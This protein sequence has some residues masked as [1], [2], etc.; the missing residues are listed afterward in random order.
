MR[1]YYLLILSLFLPCLL[2]AQE[3]G[4]MGRHFLF[5]AQGSS[6][7]VLR[8]AYNNDL[9]PNNSPLTFIPGLRMEYILSRSNTMLL[10]FVPIRTASVSEFSGAVTRERCLGVGFHYKTYAFANRGNLAPMGMFFE[11]GLN[12]YYLKSTIKDVNEPLEERTGVAIRPV[13]AF[14]NSF[15]TGRLFYEICF[16]YQFLTEVNDEY[17]GP[18][19]TNF[20]LRLSVGFL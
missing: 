6:S 5:A 8:D 2:F 14:G 3:P 13:V 7:F 16:I 18:N 10:E 15:L 11:Y 19:R 17:L 9:T 1:P 4:I 20:G 12:G